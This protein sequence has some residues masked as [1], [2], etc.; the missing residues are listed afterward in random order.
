MDTNATSQDI[1]SDTM[2]VY[3]PYIFLLPL[4]IC[5]TILSQG[6]WQQLPVV[7]TVTISGY[8]VTTILRNKLVT[9]LA[10]L[11]GAFVLGCLVNMYSTVTRRSAAE[12][13]LAGLFVQVPSGL[14]AHGSMVQSVT[15]SKIMTQIT[16]N[17]TA[18][19]TVSAT[20][21]DSIIDVT[22]PVSMARVAI[23]LA[24]GLR[25]SSWVSYL[26]GQRKLNC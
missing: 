9:E 17:G 8:A 26:L 6:R 10:N 23:M 2:P 13:L 4:V 15:K 3:F 19:M 18:Q 11:A 14:A 12:I 21:V 5:I 20:G 25:L 24:L 22:V 7:A 16:L 1:C